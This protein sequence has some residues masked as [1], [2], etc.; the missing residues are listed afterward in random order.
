MQAG[1]DSD[2]PDDGP[3]DAGGPDAGVEDAGS[4]DAAGPDAATDAGASPGP[5]ASAPSP[6]SVKVGCFA[7]DTFGLSYREFDTARGAWILPTTTPVQFEPEALRDS[8]QR[9]LG[10]HPRW[11][12]LTHYG[13][14]E[15]VQRLGAQLLR[16][17][18]EMVALGRSLA[19]AP[20][21]HAALKQGLARLYLQR[22]RAHGGTMHDATVLGLLAIHAERAFPEQEGPFGRRR[23]GLAF[24]WSGQ[25]LLA[26]GL[27]LLFGAQLAGDWLY[28]PVF[29]DLYQHLHAQP[30]PVV[31]ELRL[32][33]L[34]LVLAGTYAYVYSDLVVRKLGV[35]VYIAAF[36][37]CWLLVLCLEY[38]ILIQIISHLNTL[39]L[40]VL[41]QLV[42]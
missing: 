13:P 32:L 21:R 27:L 29:R 36:T 30:S 19:H 4:L 12:Y 3:L 42:M 35:Y 15:R 17:L 24:F 23:F 26:A 10:L 40:L 14:V 8:V 11:M 2:A 41:A 1:A 7:G 31:G 25:A 18:D 39:R 16:L 28:E 20:D 37:A 38:P 33:A 9:L 5:D 34:A 22:V 6:P